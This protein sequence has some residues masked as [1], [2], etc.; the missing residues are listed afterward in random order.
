MN[1]TQKALISGAMLGATVLGGAAGATLIGTA[2]AQTTDS[3][4]TTATATAPD[5]AH[6]PS[7]GGHVANGITEALLTGDTAAQVTTAAQGAAVAWKIPLRD[8][9]TAPFS[10]AACLRG[11]DP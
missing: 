8:Y 3:T 7:Q 1:F 9:R 2:G 5:P 6:D 10:G 11:A 4:S